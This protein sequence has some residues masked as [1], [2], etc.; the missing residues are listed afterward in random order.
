[1][2]V[3]E[4]GAGSPEEEICYTGDYSDMAPD[5]DE[6]GLPR[7]QIWGYGSGLGVVAA[8]GTSP[9]LLPLHLLKG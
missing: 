1:M 6:W 4:E 2:D 9:E 7:T 8:R 3:E 5:Y